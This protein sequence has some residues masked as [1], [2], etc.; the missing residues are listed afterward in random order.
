MIKKAEISDIDS[1]VKLHRTEL[2]TEFLPSLGKNFLIK[3][4]QDLYL[5]KNCII[6]VAKDHNNLK[7]F[8][9]G[10]KKFS[11]DFYFVIKHN[12]LKYFLLLIPQVLLHP[13]IF[14]KI[15]ETFLYTKKQGLSPD[16]ELVVIAVSKKYRRKGNGK[17]LVRELE[18]ILKKQ[19]INNYK[20]TVGASNFFY[21][22]L[23]FEELRKFKFYDKVFHVYTKKL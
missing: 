19:K 14:I 12:F 15:L 16:A 20:V 17:K 9:V 1:I 21:K 6:L 18:K 2:K 3:L 10:S 22:S 13:K 11:D 5:R 4:Y 8:I 7:G 23:R